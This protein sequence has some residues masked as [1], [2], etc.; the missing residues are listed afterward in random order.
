MKPIQSPP[1][2]FLAFSSWF[3]Q[4]INYEYPPLDAGASAYIAQL[5]AA[6]ST[7]L[8]AYL[9]ELVASDAS[10][11]ELRQLWSDSGAEWNMQ[12]IRPFLHRVRAQLAAGSGQ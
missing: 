8:N 4:D 10:D 2:S 11:D 5:D 1:A 3:H 6:G 7:E 12:P 9:G